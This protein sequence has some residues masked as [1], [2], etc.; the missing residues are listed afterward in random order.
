MAGE[1][2]LGRLVVRSFAVRSV[3]WGDAPLVTPQGE[4]IV[5]KAALPGLVESMDTIRSIDLRII[6]PDEHDQ[7]TDT[8]LDI[9][10]ISTKALGVIG[11]G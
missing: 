11:S 8:I 1:I 9:V 7:W 2:D 6:R 4:M 10:P 5:S 3:A